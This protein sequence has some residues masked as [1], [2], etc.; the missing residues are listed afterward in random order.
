MSC[1]SGDDEGR[2]GSCLYSRETLLPPSSVGMSSPLVRRKK[3]R[4]L[5]EVMEEE[6]Q[7]LLSY[8]NHQNIDALLRSTRNTLEI[9]RKRIHTSS[10]MHFLC[11]AHYF[12]GF[13][14]DEM[15]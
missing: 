7:E 5:M 11:R 3:K 8:F 12:C 14:F 2:S 13:E 6:A 4:D 15:L 9:L 1:A 10:L